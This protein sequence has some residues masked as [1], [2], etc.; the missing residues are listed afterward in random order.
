[1]QQGC[2]EAYLA[3]VG[4]A[5]KEIDRASAANHVHGPVP[6][7]GLAD[8]FDDDSTVPDRAEAEYAV[9]TISALW[10]PG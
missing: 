4:T 2:I 1:M 7:F 5:A 3:L 9:N 8:G 10:S 6:G